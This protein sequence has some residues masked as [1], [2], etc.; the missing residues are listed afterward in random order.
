MILDG[1]TNNKGKHRGSKW[2]RMIWKM[3]W[4]FFNLCVY[5]I[6]S[7]IRQ[8]FFLLNWTNN[9]QMNLLNIT[10]I[11]SVRITNHYRNETEYKLYKCKFICATWPRVVFFLLDF[12]F[13]FCILSVCVWMFDFSQLFGTIFLLLYIILLYRPICTLFLWYRQK[14]IRNKKIQTK[15]SVFVVLLSC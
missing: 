5:V 13:F 9:L 14:N 2:K 4:Y 10:S 7:Q 11:S 6:Y 1:V 12:P 15:K 8:V 3:N